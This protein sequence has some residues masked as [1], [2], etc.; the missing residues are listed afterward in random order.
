MSGSIFP[1]TWEAERKITGLMPTWATYRD[2]VSERG[3]VERQSLGLL[4]ST[5]KKLAWIHYDF[6]YLAYNA[7][8]GSIYYFIACL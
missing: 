4:P 2:P 8:G 6:Y 7:A 3:G 1:A 5:R